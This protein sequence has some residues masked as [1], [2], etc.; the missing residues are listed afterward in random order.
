MEELEPNNSENKNKQSIAMISICE[1]LPMGKST[2]PCANAEGKGLGKERQ[3]ALL[4]GWRRASGKAS[5]K[6]SVKSER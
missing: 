2:D 1:E 3:W 5:Q 4:E 6:V